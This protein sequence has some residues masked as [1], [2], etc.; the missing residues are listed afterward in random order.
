MKKRTISLSVLAVLSILVLGACGAIPGGIS[1]RANAAALDTA[2]T[3]VPSS[4]VLPAGTTSG[5]AG[6][7]AAY[8][9]TLEDIYTSV[10]PSVVNIRV[11]QQ[12][13]ASNAQMPAVPFFNTPNGQQ[14]QDQYRSGLGSGFVWDQNGHIV[15]NNHVIE[16]ADKIEVTFQDGTILPATL[17]GADPDSD[18]AVIKVDYPADKLQPV[19]IA[20]SNAVRV[21][22]LAIAIGDPFG[23][24]G[25]M[26]AGIVSAIGRSLPVGTDVGASYTIPDI[27]QTDA[28]INPGNSGGVLV[29]GEGKLIGVTA[30]IESP[31]QANAGI[32]FAIPSAIVQNVVPVLIKDGQY[33][34]A[35]LGISGTAVVPD[36]ANLMKLPAQQKGVLV[37]DVIPNSPADKAGLVGSE[38]TQTLD[39]QP[40]RIGG[41]VITQINGQPLTGIDDLIAYLASSTTVGQN[42]KLTVL[43][44]GTEKEIDVTLAARPSAEVRSQTQ[45]QVNQG[46]SLGIMGMDMNADIA[47]EMNLPKN[48]EGVLVVDVKP[49]SLAD[50]MGLRGSDQS[51]TI[52]GETLMVGGDVIT[53]V[54]GQVVTTTQELRTA[55]ADLQTG[56]MLSLT[57]VRDGSQMNIDLNLGG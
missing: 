48:Q 4:P 40:V 30:A 31:V 51:A 2:A 56:T 24:E 41:D 22:Q 57:I 45:S 14:P 37:V 28:A 5:F 20:D 10:S 17:V 16:G 23:L 8:Q 39:G 25:T 36:L 21:G 43:R 9:G 33:E 6:A 12:M 44:G 19:Q 46:V 13:D 53:A 35:W 7:V 27:I 29:D 1:T 38:E 54:N 49:G 52:Q 42:V 55:L 26:T 3:K 11:V 50:E 18:L 32:G 47:A 34:H 15:T